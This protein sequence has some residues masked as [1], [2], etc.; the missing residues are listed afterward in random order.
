M[1][2]RV[3]ECPRNAPLKA[4]PSCWSDGPTSAN[5]RCSTASRTPGAPS[6]PPSPG[7]PATPNPQPAEWQGTTVHARRYGRDVRRERRSAARARRGAGAEGA[8]DGRCHCVRG[9]WPRGLRARRRGDRRQPAVRERAGPH[10]GQQ[11]RRQAGARTARSSSISWGSSRWSRSPPS[12][13]R[14]RATCSTRSSSAC[15]RNRKATGE[16][17]PQEIAVA[18]V[19]RPN[20]GKSSLLNRLLNEERSIVSDMPG[21]TRDTVDAVLKWRAP[22]LPHRRHRR[23][24]A[25]RPGRSGRAS[26]KASASSW[27]GGRS[28]RRTWRCCVIDS[29]EGAADQDATIAGEA[30]K[31]GCGIIIAA[32]KWDLMKGQRHG[33]LEEVRRQAAAADQVPRL[34]ADA[35]HLGG[36]RRADHQG[37]RDD[38][39]GGGGARCGASRPAS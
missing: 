14:A 33:L 5:P 28:R 13:A 11:D 7:R 38:R 2:T 27:R 31:A 35:P 4:R 17:E 23:D 34:R 26:S 24:P 16:A 32:N 18:I 10:R 20:V 9:R 3:Q 1:L 8:R 39:Q 21:T 25:G 29:S 37:A 6:S 36:D 19:G 15:R 22:D 12:T 30:E